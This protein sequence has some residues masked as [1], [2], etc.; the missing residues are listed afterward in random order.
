M[1]SVSKTFEVRC[2]ICNDQ[3]VPVGPSDSYACYPCKNL[4]YESELWQYDS[5]VTVVKVEVNEQH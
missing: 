3:M 1:P 4:I 5:Q 2:D